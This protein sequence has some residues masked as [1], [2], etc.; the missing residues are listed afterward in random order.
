[1]AVGR[2]KKLP[3]T[4]SQGDINSLGE[5]MRAAGLSYALSDPPEPSGPTGS[6]KPPVA[7]PKGAVLSLRKK[8]LGG[9]QCT[10]VKLR[11][12]DPSEASDLCRR[13]K[14]ALGCGARLD[15]DGGDELWVQG[16]QRERLKR[17]LDGLGF[18]VSGG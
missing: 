7:G 12:V 6:R 11:G 1:M 4:E 15:G 2:S 8:G 17:L 9:H 13:V 16:D 10:V 14:S 18:K 3:L 5:A